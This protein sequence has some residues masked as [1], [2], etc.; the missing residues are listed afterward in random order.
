MSCKWRRRMSQIPC[1]RN[2]LRWHQ[3]WLPN[4]TVHLWKEKWWRYLLHLRRTRE[5]PP[6]AARATV[7]TGNQADVSVSPSRDT[8]QQS[9]LKFAAAT[10]VTP[11]AGRFSSGNFPNPIQAAFPEL[12]LAL[13]TDPRLIWESSSANPPAVTVSQQLSS[14]L[15][16]HRHPWATTRGLPWWLCCGRHGT[17]SRE[18][19]VGVRLI[20]TLQRCWRPWKAG[21]DYC[22]KGCDG[23]GISGFSNERVWLLK[24]SP[25]LEA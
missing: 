2:P 8:G 20:S 14:V 11:I 3:T 10:G 15:R 13:V 17:S 1:R 9:V 7:A 18:H 5:K 12:R 23:R 6:L 21:V 16:G 4:A 25:V 24:V 19:Q 22:R